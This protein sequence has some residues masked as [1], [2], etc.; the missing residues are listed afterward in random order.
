[1]LYFSKNKDYVD[2]EK[3]ER[4]LRCNGYILCCMDE[5]KMQNL[6]EAALRDSRYVYALDIMK[7][8]SEYLFSSISRNVLY[9]YLT[10]IEGCPERY[11]N[12]R[13]VR[14][15]SLDMKKVLLPLYNNG[16]AQEFLEAYMSYTSTVSR[17]SDVASLLQGMRDSGLCNKH[18]QRLGKILYTVNQQ[19]NLRY[20]YRNYD[21][22]SQIPKGYTEN[23]SVEDGYF[24]AW[25]DFAQADLRIAYNLLLRDS[26]NYKVMSEVEDKY[27]G[28]ARLVAASNNEEF[29][30][31]KFKRERNLYKVYVLETLYGTRAATTKEESEFVKK[32][33][34][35][36]E[37]CEK[38]NEYLER[39]RN[40]HRLNLPI[41]T[42]GYFGYEQPVPPHRTT[43]SDTCNF[44]LNSP[45]Q[46]GT[47][48][49]MILTVNRI[50]DRFRE[51]GY[52]EDDI[53][54][55]VVRHDEVVFRCKESILQDAWMF[56]E[57]SQIQ[58]DDWI[59]MQLDFSF[60]YQYGKP[61]EE[62]TDLVMKNYIDNEWKV[63][64]VTPQN[65]GISERYFPVSEV[66]HLTYHLSKVGDKT[67]LAVV[68]G[69][70]KAYSVYVINSTDAKVVE[71]SIVGRIYE[72][73]EM[74]PEE[75]YQG[76]LIESNFLK[77]GLFH[78]GR[79]LKFECVSNAGLYAAQ[80]LS[81]VYANTYARQNG[82]EMPYRDRGKE[83]SQF[84]GYRQL[85]TLFEK[86]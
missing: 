45:I 68:D 7:R 3:Y 82:L 61:D 19:T 48:E 86:R 35:Y 53:S 51:L 39:I 71:K 56:K 55:Y 14:G 8:R 75:Q 1:M 64:E 24:L 23:I 29:D 69:K 74:Y 84:S 42:R 85:S 46:T 63:K 78:N 16:Y 30:Y 26:E 18:G 50:L 65:V 32:L 10:Q 57:A 20:N 44:A 4:N 76:T 28:I 49:L 73:V 27:E 70:L 54:V 12:K 72:I 11:F 43:L 2:T 59:P 15:T 41:V 60:G 83:V 37:G 38:Y 40:R 52:S 9:N 62:L 58:V 22:I 80:C 31:K 25:G 17:C 13:G 21:I 5:M 36:L 67:I 34:K 6:F 66:I 81:E 33:N 47:S 77:G 79:L